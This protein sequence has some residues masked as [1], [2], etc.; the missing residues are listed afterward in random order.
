M[1]LEK[2]KERYVASI[3]RCV[4]HS[5]RCSACST[6]GAGVGKKIEK[7]LAVKRRGPLALQS[8][9]RQS[10]E[11]RWLRQRLRCNHITRIDHVRVDCLAV[12]PVM[13]MVV[14]VNQPPL[15]R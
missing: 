6:W 3:E 4:V 12:H 8:S 10:S 1:F 14:V 5:L 11:T 7:K 15:Q 9:A 2:E 13:M